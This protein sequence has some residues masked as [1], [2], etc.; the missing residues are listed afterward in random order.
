M[1]NPP[2]ADNALALFR[3]RQFLLLWLAG[4]CASTVRWLEMLATAVFVFEITRSPFTLATL[5]ALRMLPLA[6][7][8]ALAGVLA[9]RWDRRRLQLIG[10]ALMV[11]LSG[12]QAWLVLNGLI[13][14]WHVALGAF[15]NGVFWTTDMPARRT[16]LGDAAGPERIGAAMS[17]D[18]V[19]GN[20]T[21]MLGPLLGGL[22]LATLGLGG[23]FV[24]GA[25]LYLAALL[26]V[27][28]LPPP[29]AA[30]PTGGDSLWA[31]L[32]DGLR[33]VRG[34]RELTGTLL[35]TLVF[36]LWAF[37][38][39]SMVPVLGKEIYGLGPL[40]VGVLASMEGLGAFSGAIAIG[41]L[42]QPRHYHKLYLLGSAGLLVAV[43]LLALAPGFAVAAPLLVAAGLCSAGFASMQ[44][45]LTFLA[46]PAAVRRRVMGVLSVCIGVGPI[47]FLHIGA[48]AQWLGAP[49]ALAVSSVEG[50]L[51][52]A[53]VYRFWPQVR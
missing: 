47:G 4:A 9:E 36:N 21:R 18:S 19:T 32:T 14:L 44:A 34:N 42:A 40:A 10:L 27:Y 38:F 17:F 7:F 53:L 16:L 26:A 48:L 43:M 46:A 1:S 29:P 39:V 2:A 3:N 22:L 45:T 33:Y 37:P 24:L 15:L 11:M 25:A 13:Q 12:L 6:L 50:L 31:S 8:G 49:G 5:I 20:G 35:I 51:A 41:L 23:T 52:L 30:G 28:R